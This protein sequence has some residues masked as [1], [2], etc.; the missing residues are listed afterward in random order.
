LSSYFYIVYRGGNVKYYA[1]PIWDYDR[2]I[3]NSGFN[4]EPD[5]F[6]A[7]RLWKRTDVYI[8]YYGKLNDK[9]VFFDELC[10]I[11]KD[12]IRPMLDSLVCSGGVL[13][14]AGEIKEASS[15]NQK[16]CFRNI[17][18]PMKTPQDLVVHLTQ[19]M[20]LLDKIY[21]ERI[22]VVLVSYERIGRKFYCYKTIPKGEKLDR[23]MLVGAEQNPDVEWALKG[24][25]QPF[26]FSRELTED[27]VLD[28]L[29]K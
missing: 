19:R 14:L 21:G 7:R 17:E 8:P 24:T 25:D 3:G 15:I 2:S 1:G 11:Y 4:Y 10:K 13:S 23:T 28:I 5:M 16:C 29:E 27:I 9:P 6:L 12:D 18:R 20:D 22:Q 26:D